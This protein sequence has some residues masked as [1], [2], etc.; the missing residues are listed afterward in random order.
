MSEHD[1]ELIYKFTALI[2]YKFF[3]CNNYDDVYYQFTDSQM[4]DLINRICNSEEFD[5]FFK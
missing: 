1:K 4:S 5:E 3:F 2:K